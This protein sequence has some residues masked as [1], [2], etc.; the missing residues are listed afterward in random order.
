ML[1][2]LSEENSVI[3]PAVE[4]ALRD[5]DGARSRWPAVGPAQRATLLRT[6]RD[7][8]WRLAQR[9]VD[10]SLQAKAERPGSATEGEEWAYV[11]VTLKL[12]RQ[13]AGSMD[14]L[15]TGAAPRLP[16]P[17]KTASDGQVR[18]QVVPA[19]RGETQS[20]PGTTGEVWLM[21]GVR[22]E[23]VVAAQAKAIRQPPAKAAVCLMLGAGNVSMLVPSDVLH[24]LFVE[25]HVVLLKMNPVNEYLGEL[26]RE[27]FAPLI[28]FGCLRV[29]TC[30][31]QEAAAL[32]AHPTVDRLHMTGSDRTFEAI[33]FGTD[34]DASLRKAQGTLK[35]ARPFTSE[36]GNVTPVIVVPGP[37]SAK[38]FSAQGKHLASLASINASFGCLTPRLIVQ[39]ASWDG[40]QTLLET[41]RAAF[42][43]IPTRNAYY[44]G[45]IER[46]RR[47]LEA[48]PQ[49]ERFGDPAP[50]HLPW[51]LAVDVPSDGS[52][53]LFAEESFCPFL[54]EVG[55]VATSVPE[56]LEA[57][58][59]FVNERVWGNLVVTVLVH[60]ASMAD[61]TIQAAVEK[62]VGALK[63]GTVAVNTSGA[64]T[65]SHGTLPWGAFAGNVPTDIQSG[66]GFVNNTCML[67]R[68]QKVVVRGPFLVR[69]KAPLD[70]TSRGW[71]KMMRQVA[72]LEAQPGFLNMVR[73][74]AALIRS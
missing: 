2:A 49:A 20:A 65:F 31:Q 59:K 16:G 43:T 28:D 22:A 40:R 1:N 53:R 67:D 30:G 18:V 7:R 58:V 35:N 11:V 48:F 26:M 32:C 57:A 4:A 51:T 17:V 47:L 29:V 63:Y 73:L 13:L 9:W 72:A 12:L 14:E 39:H 69:G 61:P 52:H 64:S 5:L 24:G 37:W 74:L 71:P 56:Y 41:L 34:A 10:V 44:P 55:L 21:P 42:R 8:F 66:S 46:H 38:D 27:A 6:C 25:N 45:A 54:A 68:P 19:D 23:D 60:P 3:G 36:L 33:A 70:L 50:G 62:A 15:A